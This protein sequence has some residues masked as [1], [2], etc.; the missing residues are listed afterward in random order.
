[1]KPQYATLC[2]AAFAVACQAASRPSVL[3]LA[4]A[5]VLAFG[6]MWIPATAEEDEP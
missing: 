4:L 1:M 3:W 2:L 6:V 5:I